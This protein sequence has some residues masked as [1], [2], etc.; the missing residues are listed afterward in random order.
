MERSNDSY[1]HFCIHVFKYLFYLHLNVLTNPNRYFKLYMIRTE[2]L[3]L[4]ATPPA[5]ITTICSTVSNPSYLVECNL[6]LQV[7][8]PK[9]LKLP[10]I[11]FFYNHNQCMSNS[12]CSVFKIHPQSALFL[13]SLLYDQFRKVKVIARFEF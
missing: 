4:P 1:P 12:S 7:V 6:V 13:L 9:F 10:L 8:Q 5:T 11:F 3:I 2:L